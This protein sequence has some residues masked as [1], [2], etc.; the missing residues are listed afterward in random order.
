[1]Y[2]EGT[3]STRRDLVNPVPRTLVIHVC[4]NSNSLKTRSSEAVIFMRG[5]AA[6]YWINFCTTTA[7]EISALVY[8]PRWYK[9]TWDATAKDRL[10]KAKRNQDFAFESRTTVVV[11]KDHYSHHMTLLTPWKG[12]WKGWI[13]SSSL[14]VFVKVWL[15]SSHW[16]KRLIIYAALHN[17]F[18]KVVQKIDKTRN[19]LEYVATSRNFRHLLEFLSPFRMSPHL[20]NISFIISIYSL[21]FLSQTNRVKV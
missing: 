15:P 7:E 6:K 3:P 11:K 18:R 10:I 13:H 9:K 17:A 5:C 12:W 21:L 8:T 20:K 2:D 14:N 16:L 4:N 19:L 1:M